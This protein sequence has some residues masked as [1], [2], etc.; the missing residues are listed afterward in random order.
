MSRLGI[1]GAVLAMGVYGGT[2][3]K[4]EA[5]HVTKANAPQVT[6]ALN[7]GDEAVTQVQWGRFFGGLRG[8][9]YSPYSS[10]YGPAYGYRSYY[11]PYA[12]GYYGSYGYGNP[13]V[14]WW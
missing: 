3:L 11:S 7:H 1:L 9:Y 10:Y 8:G 13:Y 12:G 2:L 5:P 4:T 14:W 6:T